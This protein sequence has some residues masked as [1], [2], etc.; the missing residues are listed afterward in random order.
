MMKTMTTIILGS[1]NKNSN[2]ITKINKIF[3]KI[4]SRIHSRIIIGATSRINTKINKLVRGGKNRMKMRT[5]ITQW[6][7]GLKK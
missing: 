6:R 1:N 5:M 3:R 4:M 7:R 2:Y